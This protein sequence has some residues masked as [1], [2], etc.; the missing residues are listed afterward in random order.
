LSCQYQ[1]ASWRADAIKDCTDFGDGVLDAFCGS[2]TTIIA[3]EKVDR[4]AYGIE[5][6]P[7][8]VDVAI[9]RWER[10]T[11][12]AAVHAETGMTFAEMAA[13]RSAETPAHENDSASGVSDLRR[14]G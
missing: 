5:L 14:E 8:Y 4:V 13:L 1:T 12:R 3:A 2:G 7:V 6:D 9:G 11:K 10:L